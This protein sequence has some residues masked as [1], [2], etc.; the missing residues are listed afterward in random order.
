[1]ASRCEVVLAGLNEA[2]A[3]RLAALA[4]AEVHRIEQKYSRF[5]PDSVIGQINARAATEAVP[6]DEETRA[7][8]KYADHLFDLSDGLFDITSGLL[9]SVW[10]FKNKVIPSSKDIQPLLEHVGWREVEVS[11]GTIRFAKPKMQIDFGGF[12]KEYAADR[13]ADVMMQSG[14]VSGYVNLGGDVRAL[15]PRPD[16]TPWVIGIRH[17]RNPEKLMA[18]IPL[19]RG[20]LATSGDYERFMEKDG[21]RYCHILNPKTGWPVSTWQSISAIAP[22]TITAGTCTTIAML[23]EQAGIGFLEESHLAYLA[24]DQQGRIHQQDDT[25]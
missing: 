3:T 18:S 10:D 24:I 14:A 7:L 22:L 13:A 2:E 20:G 19:E 16:G 5:L 1:M 25:T 8:L 21:K 6:I 4:E 11:E 15:G 23:K 9:Q 12:G 17:P